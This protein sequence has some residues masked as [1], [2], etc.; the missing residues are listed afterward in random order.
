MKLP[1]RENK[2][3]EGGV[4]YAKKAPPQKLIVNRYMNNVYFCKLAYEP[5][6]KELR[7]YE[8]ELTDEISLT[9]KSGADY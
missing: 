8:S 9:G 5:T 1:R 7:Y 2:F 3:I 6:L 4:V